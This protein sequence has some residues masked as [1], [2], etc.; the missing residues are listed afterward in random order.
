MI[1][2]EE[3]AKYRFYQCVTTSIGYKCER[4]LRP[5][6]K[7][8]PNSQLILIDNFVPNIDLLEPTI[9]KWKLIPK[10]VHIHKE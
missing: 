7:V 6:Y 3:F 1:N 10:T 4:V 8:K 9:L 5:D 2:E